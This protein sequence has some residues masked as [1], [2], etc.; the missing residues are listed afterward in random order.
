[1]DRAIVKELESKREVRTPPA[2]IRSADFW[3]KR[4]SS[5]NVHTRRKASLMVMCVNR[6][7]YKTDV[8]PPAHCPVCNVVV[9]RR[10]YV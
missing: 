1:M 9:D 4:G 3:G 6:H 8:K 5:L 7:D 10:G 2:G